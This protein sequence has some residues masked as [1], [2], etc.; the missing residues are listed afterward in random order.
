MG[1]FGINVH[2]H[3]HQRQVLVDESD[4]SSIDPRYFN[5]SVERLDY[6]PMALEDLKKTVEARGGFWGFKN[7]N[8]PQVM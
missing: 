3:L 8:E 1:R 4:P 5:V 6:T 2:G 7:G